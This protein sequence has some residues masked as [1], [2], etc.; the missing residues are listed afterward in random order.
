MKKYILTL[1]IVLVLTL[2]VRSQDQ[3]PSQYYTLAWNITFP[4]GDFKDWVDNTSLSGFD[5][6]GRYLINNGIVA[7]FNIGWQRIN[8][9][10]ENQTYTIPDRGIA[11]TADNYRITY[12]VPFQAVIAYHLTPGKMV[13]P[14]ISLGIGG[15]YMQHH[16]V[17]QE[18]DLYKEKWDFTLTPEVGALAK[19][20]EFS[21]WGLL[22]AFNYKW[23]TNKIELYEETSENLQMLNLKV[24]VVISVY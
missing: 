15:D 21:N 18:Y 23:T 12:M 10:Y 24:G 2:N 1:G 9:L 20:S 4:M 16:L 6:G 11:I 3:L 22:V 17:I 13:T 7:G 5:F 8:K 14:Y 19:F